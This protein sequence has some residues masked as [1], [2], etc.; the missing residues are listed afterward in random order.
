ML[1][2]C[3]SRNDAVKSNDAVEL[4]DDDRLCSA[5]TVLRGFCTSVS[6][7]NFL[8]AVLYAGSFS[9]ILSL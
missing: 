8:A 6:Y 5:V 3:S 7:Q 1:Y 9:F 4:S 2:R